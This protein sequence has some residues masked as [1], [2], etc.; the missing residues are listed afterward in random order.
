[1][2]PTPL[3]IAKKRFSI[4]EKD[5]TKAR[6]AAKEK[7]VAAVEKLAE[8]G[9]WIDRLHEDK[10]LASVSN[11]KLLHLLDV[12]EAVKADFGSRDKLIEAIVDQE[13]RK[14]AGLKD[15]YAKWPTPRLFAHHQSL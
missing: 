2:K 6:H 10:G 11:K 4:D 3:A 8:S 7:L 13:G 15:R 12:L 1:M 14:D 5:P 9:L